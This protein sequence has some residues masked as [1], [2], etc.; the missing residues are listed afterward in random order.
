MA[1]IIVNSNPSFERGDVKNNPSHPGTNGNDI[2][3]ISPGSHGYPMANDD[4]NRSGGKDTFR[5]STDVDAKNKTP[6]PYQE[7][8]GVVSIQNFGIEDKIVLPRDV[9]ME[10]L[11]ILRYGYHQ[12]PNTKEY[13]FSFE[14]VHDPH[15]LYWY[16]FGVG[17]NI[18]EECSRFHMNLEEGIAKI[19]GN[20]S[21]N[22]AWN[23][24][25]GPE[26]DPEHGDPRAI[27]SKLN[28][29]RDPRGFEEC[30]R[31][32]SQNFRKSDLYLSGS[33]IY[34]ADRL[35]S[36]ES[37]S[38]KEKPSLHKIMR[39]I[40]TKD[41]TNFYQY[42]HSKTKEKQGSHEKPISIPNKFKAKAVDKITRFNPSTDTLE[43][44]TDSFGI[45]RSANFATG[46][47]K[48]KVKQ[49]ANKDFDF[50]Y[51][52]KKGGLY[53]NENGADKGFGD[54]GIIAILKG[55]PG[56]TTNNLEFI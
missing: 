29:L 34:A 16:L 14:L 27:T 5:L 44:H 8:G 19:T 18:T 52:Q 53:F 46:K 7:G 22:T 32:S 45:N 6:H 35:A 23:T 13:Q 47:N 54:G 21:R 50:L 36:F 26:P 1:K 11:L 30:Q 9:P 49:L 55:A 25:S 28:Q 20:T 51:D 4:E 56:L 33:S 24:K 12:N 37:T 31:E 15:D 38:S 48:R 43:I 10:E 40:S 2:F 17:A 42:A 3:I 41:G 39:S